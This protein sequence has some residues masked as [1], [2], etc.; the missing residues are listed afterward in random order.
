MVMLIVMS[1]DLKII[2]QIAEKSF[3]KFS[4]FKFYL[5]MGFLL[6]LS[7]KSYKIHSNIKHYKNTSFIDNY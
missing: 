7:I 2:Y 5:Y 3:K 4:K 1:T 6:N